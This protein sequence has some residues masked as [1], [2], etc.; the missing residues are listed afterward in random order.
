MNTI[1]PI[2]SVVKIRDV[3]TPVMIFGF[4][5]ETSTKPGVLVDYVGVPYPA[6]NINMAYQLGFQMSDITE[7]LFEGYRTEEFKPME[8]LLQLR[9]YSETRKTEA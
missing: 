8:A 3:D 9:L 5:Q 2:G 1:L 7:V 6:G 4:L